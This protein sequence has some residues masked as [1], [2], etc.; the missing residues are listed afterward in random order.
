MTTVSPRKKGREPATNRIATIRPH[1]AMATGL[2]N[3]TRID[4][5]TATAAPTSRSSSKGK[6]M[7]LIVNASTA[8]RKPTTV[9]TT[10]AVQPAGVVKI[11]LTN[12]LKETGAA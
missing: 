2:A 11:S 6:E 1:N 5:K 7:A 3:T 9:P 8:N 4:V 10:I 12:L